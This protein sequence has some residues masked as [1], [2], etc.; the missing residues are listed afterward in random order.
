MEEKDGLILSLPLVIVRATRRG[1]SPPPSLRGTQRRGN[2]YGGSASQEAGANGKAD[3]IATS[4]SP[5]ND[6]EGLDCGL[7]EIVTG[8]QGMESIVFE[9]NDRPWRVRV[10]GSIGLF[11]KQLL[12]DAALASL[13]SS[14]TR[15][16]ARAI[17]P[18]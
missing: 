3:W 1:N 17:A 9:Q 11:L 5:S 15:R 12:R 18:A 13:R 8:F 4:R 7:S 14:K 6:E 2:P 16:E 10:G